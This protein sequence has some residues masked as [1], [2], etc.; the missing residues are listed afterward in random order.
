VGSLLGSLCVFAV[1]APTA[2]AAGSIEGTV[3]DAVGKEPIEG[4]EVCAWPVSIEEEEVAAG[5]CDF[6]AADG[7]YAIASQPAGE[8]EVEFWAEGY[9]GLIYP[10]LVTV[11]TGST[12]GI[13]AELEQAPG[14]EGTVTRSSDGEPVE[15]V[16][17]C[18]WTAISEE[19]GGCG[20]TGADGIYLISGLEQGEYEVGFFTG[21]TG[22]NLAVEIY[23]DKGRWTEANF[24]TVASGVT[25]GID[26]ALESG[27]TISGTV[28][29]PNGALLEGI[30]VCSIALPGDVLWT[31]AET[32]F[33]GNY[34]LPT[35]PQGDYKVVFSID[36]E[37]WFEEEFFEEADGYLTEYWDDQS[38]LAAANVISLTV[39]ES[40][41]D[42]NAILET[43]PS[44]IPPGT[45]PPGTTPPS[46]SPPVAN[47]PTAAPRK[48][49]CRR[50]FRKKKVRGKVRCV[51]VRKHRRHKRAAASAARAYAPQAQR[52]LFAGSRGF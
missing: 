36:F 52:R 33:G 7:T 29:A 6:T 3:I 37:E 27:A 51:K 13:D 10:G 25:P 28:S 5:G 2:L 31:C 26:A 48:R 21:E 12:T 38:T 23:D 50:G 42:I 44:V 4:V 34:S 11:G 15:D 49:K 22:Q 17:V 24:V 39:G 18:A 35:L 30:P 19:F 20:W 16:E 32:D 9:E 8:Y 46:V 43:A 45:T 1:L 40:T 41:G 47:P 14:I